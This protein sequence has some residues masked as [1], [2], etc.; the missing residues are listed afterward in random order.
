MVNMVYLLTVTQAH[1]QQL[2]NSVRLLLAELDQ[3][4][5]VDRTTADANQARPK[6]PNETDSGRSLDPF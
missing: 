2:R 6:E 3:Q 5:E 4:Q 1:L